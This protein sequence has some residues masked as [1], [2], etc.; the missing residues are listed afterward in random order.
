MNTRIL[1]LD[2]SNQWRWWTLWGT[3]LETYATP[4]G[5]MWLFPPATCV[6]L[7]RQWLNAHGITRW[8]CFILRTLAPGDSGHLIPSVQPG[9][10]LLCHTHGHASARAVQDYADALRSRRIDPQGAFSLHRVAAP[11]LRLGHTPP[12][13]LLDDCPATSAGGGRA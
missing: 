5:T 10:E 3:P 1:N 9:A 8:E 2:V 12:A 11:Y 13:S 4:R 6:G 7:S